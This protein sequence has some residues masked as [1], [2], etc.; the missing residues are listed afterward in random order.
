[1][2]ALASAE[3]FQ[4]SLQKLFPGYDQ[5]DGKS[6]RLYQRL[7]WA[8]QHIVGHDDNDTA[9]HVGHM[10][11][12][13]RQE[14]CRDICLRCFVRLWNWI[15]DGHGKHA[16]GDKLADRNDCGKDSEATVAHNSSRAEWVLGAGSTLLAGLFMSDI[17]H[18]LSN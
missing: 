3:F 18:M 7:C 6:R 13:R 5:A 11:S 14:P 16:L 4:V 17:C 2:V 15:L 9:V 10:A 12:I 8:L 1:M